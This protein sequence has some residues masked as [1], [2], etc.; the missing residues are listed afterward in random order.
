MKMLTVYIPE[1]Y[2]KTLETKKIPL[3][4]NRIETLTWNKIELNSDERHYSIKRDILFLTQKNKV[5]EQEN[6]ICK[7]DNTLMLTSRSWKITKPL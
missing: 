6:I 1:D 4:R 7:D 2:I 3:F 5:L